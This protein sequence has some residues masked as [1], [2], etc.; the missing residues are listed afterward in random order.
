MNLPRN[1]YLVYDLSDSSITDSSITEREVLE[2]ME[3]SFYLL[4]LIFM[5]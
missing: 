3:P 2:I 4:V 5:I 1:K